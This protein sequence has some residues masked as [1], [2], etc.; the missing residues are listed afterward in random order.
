MNV[1]MKKL[2]EVFSSMVALALTP[3]P[4]RRRQRRRMWRCLSA[5]GRISA[6]PRAASLTSPTPLTIKDAN[7]KVVWDLE[8][9]KSYI[10]VDKPAPDSVNPAF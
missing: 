2:A 1:T 10:S 9:Y 3:V 7:G 6:M 4:L 5:T 8:T